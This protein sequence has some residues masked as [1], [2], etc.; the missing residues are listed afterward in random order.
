M[1]TTSSSV[2]AKQINSR[3]ASLLAKLPLSV[4]VGIGICAGLIGGFLMNSP[5]AGN[6]VSTSFFHPLT[7]TIES[8]DTASHTFEL[9]NETS[10]VPLLIHYSAATLWARITASADGSEVQ[11]QTSNPT[12][13]TANAHASIRILSTDDLQ[14]YSVK[15]YP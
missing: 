11:A 5:L 15:W 12:E 2:A 1:E 14:A 9:K 8:I 3:S 4:T 13:I 10:A 6:S 7:G